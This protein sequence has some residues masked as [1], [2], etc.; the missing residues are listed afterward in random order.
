VPT[1]TAVKIVDASALG[2]ML[3]GEAEAVASRL[4]NARLTAPTLLT[5]ELANVYV[6]KTRHNKGL[7]RQGDAVLRLVHRLAI[8]TLAVDIAGMIKLAEA[9]GLTAYD[10]SY[11]WLARSLGGELITLDRQLAKAAAAVR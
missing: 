11:L 6:T 1:A 2:A 5:F 4:E 9:M 3:F 10:A 7:R 8:E